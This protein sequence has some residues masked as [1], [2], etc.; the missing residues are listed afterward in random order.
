ML[1]FEVN[2]PI[3]AKNIVVSGSVNMC[4]FFLFLLRHAAYL[5]AIVRNVYYFLLYDTYA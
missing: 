1:K 2:Q 4:N 3:F 5:S